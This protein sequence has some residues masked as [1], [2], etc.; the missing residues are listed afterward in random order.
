MCRAG[1]GVMRLRWLTVA[2]CVSLTA[3]VPD[4]TGPYPSVSYP[5]GYDGSSGYAQP[6]Y[7]PSYVQPGYADPGYGYAPPAYGYAQPYP[8]PVPVR[9]Y[10]GGYYGREREFRRDDGDRFARERFERNRFER[11]RPQFQPQRS[12]GI[13]PAP[14]ELRPQQQS[15]QRQAPPP[16]ARRPPPPQPS[17]REPGQGGFPIPSPGQLMR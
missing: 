16:E 11:E 7:A 10:G 6:G 1:D 2:A 14:Q 15:F 9:P 12:P 8:V 5:S 17:R 4:G 13:L 3:C